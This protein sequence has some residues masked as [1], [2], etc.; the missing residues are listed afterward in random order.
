[1]SVAPPAP[2]RPRSPSPPSRRAALDRAAVLLRVERDVSRLDNVWG[3][4]GGQRPVKHLVKEVS[5]APARHIVP[6]PVPGSPIPSPH[7]LSRHRIPRPVVTMSPILALHPLVLSPCPP[8]CHHVP[9]SCHCVPLRR[10]CV[11]QPCHRTPLLH[12]SSLHPPASRCLLDVPCHVPLDMTPAVSPTHP[13]A[14]P[15]QW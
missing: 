8:S 14:H 7:P 2:P 4:G 15:G 13:H 3:A 5:A 1:M 6:C 9:W 11:P 12:P 10:H